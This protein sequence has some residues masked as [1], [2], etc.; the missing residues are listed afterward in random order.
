M[1]RAGIAVITPRSRKAGI[2][3]SAA[4]KT[5]SAE[6]GREAAAVGLEEADDAPEVR[7]AHLRVGRTLGLRPRRV[8]EHAHRLRVRR[9]A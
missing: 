7:A 9:G 1:S 4:E 3:P 2:T 8:E 6:Q 5:I